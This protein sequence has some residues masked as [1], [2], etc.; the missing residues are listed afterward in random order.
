[1]DRAGAGPDRVR[2]SGIVLFGHLGV[3][4]AERLV[5]QKLNIDV[6]M[7]C[8]L[9]AAAASDHLVDTIDYEKAYRLVERTVTE[10]H[11][12]L[13]EA[14]AGTLCAALLDTFPVEQVTVRVQ[15]P[16][17]PFA[18]TVSAAEVELTRRR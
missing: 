17:V 3:H 8:D 11:F 18:G 16:N 6:E 10:G 14:L 12:K 4:E 5:G 15:K 2:L 1:M 9:S 13:I 7:R